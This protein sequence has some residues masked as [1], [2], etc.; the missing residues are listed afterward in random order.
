[1]ASRLCRRR[2]LLAV[3]DDAAHVVG[4]VGDADFDSGAV[5]AEGSHPYPYT[6]LLIG[7][8]VF[9]EGAEL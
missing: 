7:E 2:G 8:D 1:M 4:D 9:D 3:K 5:D 6:A